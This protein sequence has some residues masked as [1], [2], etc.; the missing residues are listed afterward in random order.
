MYTDKFFSTVYHVAI[1]LYAYLK[2]KRIAFPLCLLEQEMSTVA[3]PSIDPNS[4]RSV[5]EISA[6]LSLSRSKVYQL[7]E[8]GELPYIKFGKSRRVRWGDVLQLVESHRVGSV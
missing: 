6:Y 4:L 7:M 2:R 5:R 1:I 8:S 3:P